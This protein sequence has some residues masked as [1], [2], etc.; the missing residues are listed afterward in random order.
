VLSWREYAEPLHNIIS[1]PYELAVTES[2]KVYRIESVDVVCG[3][4][5]HCHRLFLIEL[6]AA[7]GRLLQRL[8]VKA[9][10]GDLQKHIIDPFEKEISFGRERPCDVTETH[11]LTSFDGGLIMAINLKTGIVD[12][13]TTLPTGMPT[14]TFFVLNN[15]FYVSTGMS[16]YIFEGEGGYIPD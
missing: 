13:H 8:E 14:S 9:P 15:R 6:E 4:D 1:R 12:W 10:E 2:G 7:T 16:S 3:Y 5:Q 11:Y